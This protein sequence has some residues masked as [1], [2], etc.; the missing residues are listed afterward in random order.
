VVD[1]LEWEGSRLREALAIRKPLPGARYA[2]GSYS[3]ALLLVGLHSIRALLCGRPN[4][5]PLSRAHG[6]PWRLVVSGGT[7][8]ISVKGVGSPEL[9]SG[10]G[11]TAEAIARG[12]PVRVGCAARPQDVG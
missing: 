8:F 12:R 4:S 5:T 2:R 1:D 11:A 3:V 9:A 7:C 10:P 6:A